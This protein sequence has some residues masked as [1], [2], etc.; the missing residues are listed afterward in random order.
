MRDDAVLAWRLDDAKIRGSGVL[1]VKG[2][3]EDEGERELLGAQ[4][5]LSFLL[6]FN[7]TKNGSKQPD[8]NASTPSKA[9]FPFHK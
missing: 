4:T 7:L 2:A 5:D 1:H 8:I 3:E 9:P 6:K